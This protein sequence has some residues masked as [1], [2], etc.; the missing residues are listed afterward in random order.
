MDDFNAAEFKV[1]MENLETQMSNVSGK[2]DKLTELIQQMKLEDRDT[3]NRLKSV[4]KDVLELKSEQ[5]IIKETLT[6]IKQKPVKDKAERWQQIIDYTFKS[7]MA[8][9]I[10]G[11]LAKIGINL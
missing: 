6:E 7:L 9:A 5:K 10:I 1:K 4:E 8:V 2:L 11:L 3:D